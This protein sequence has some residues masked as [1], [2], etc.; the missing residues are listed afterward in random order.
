MFYSRN[1]KKESF[2]FDL[3]ISEA[4]SVISQPLVTI[5]TYLIP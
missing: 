4:S 5:N 1:K 2:G 3:S